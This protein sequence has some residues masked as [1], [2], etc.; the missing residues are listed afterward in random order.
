MNIFGIYLRENS[1][2]I[3]FKTHQIAVVRG[4]LFTLWSGGGGSYLPASYGTKIPY[5]T[6]T[7][8]YD[9]L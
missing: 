2:K 1:I 4:K 9:T 6:T 7:I 5:K 3:Y 8:C